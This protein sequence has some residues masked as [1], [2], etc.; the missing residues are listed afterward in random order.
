[1]SELRIFILV[2][3]S[4]LH[5][6]LRYLSPLKLHPGIHLSAPLRRAHQARVMN[7]PSEPSGIH[8]PCPP[9]ILLVSH[10]FF[11][12]SSSHLVSPLIMSSASPPFAR[13]HPP[14]MPLAISL[15]HCNPL[16]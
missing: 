14:K 9:S 6:A 11:F 13:P 5:V 3:S 10:L 8:S 15:L 16:L 7:A 1:M 2:I 4:L 12:S